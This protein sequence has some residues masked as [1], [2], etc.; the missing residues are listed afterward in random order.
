[1]RFWPF[2]KKQERFFSK[3]EEKIIITAIK[4]AEKRT[5]GEIR[6]HVES[7]CHKN[8][9]ERALEVFTELKMHKTKAQNGILFYLAMDSSLMAVIGDKGIHD[10]VGA[11]FW[12]TVKDEAIQDFKQKLF[13]KGLEKAIIKCGEVLNQYFPYEKD[14]KNELEDDISYG[15]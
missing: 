14:D 2:N 8:P 13:A 4:F 7:T 10:K 6:L 11:D 15:Q 5:S 3:D 12:E 1:M 9:I